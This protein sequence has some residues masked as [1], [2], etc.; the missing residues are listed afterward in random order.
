MG[1]VEGGA[2]AAEASYAG[3]GSTTAT[4]AP[5]AWASRLKRSQAI[6][7]GVSTAAH[8]VRAGDSAGGGHAVDL[9]EKNP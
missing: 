4:S 3:S 9:S 2:A 7:H 5:P 8:A 1:T 6:R